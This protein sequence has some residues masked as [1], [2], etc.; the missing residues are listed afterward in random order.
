MKCHKIALLLSLVSA[1]IFSNSAFAGIL[2]DIDWLQS[3]KGDANLVIVDVQNKPGS[4]EKGHIPEAER[5]LRHV[6][7][8]DPTRYPANK[9]PG[10]RQFV[11][12]MSRLGID[13]NTTVVAYDD[14]P[15]VFASRILFILE[16]YGHDVDKLKLLNGGIKQWEAKGLNVSTKLSKTRVADRYITNGP[17]LTMLV[18]WSD[19]LHDVVHKQNTN[20]VL[21][22]ARP[23]KEFNGTKIRTIR[24]GHIPG[25]I[26]L[27]GVKAANNGDL[28]FKSEGDI[29]QK[30]TDAGISQDKTIYTY[31]HSS[32]RSAHA[33]M[34]MKHM[35]GYPNVKIYEGA[36]NE[37]GTMT[38]LPAADEIY[39]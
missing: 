14:K 38:A 10:T 2:V 33:Y 30:F 5:V 34:V 31:C 29:Q 23:A 26:N 11:Q 13:N 4:F 35:L 28:T 36:W 12:L 1:V 3:H 25:A 24:G 22:D 17:D 6:D 32:D 39:Q 18:T 15:S 8:E 37:W 27:E 16:L 21:H 20:I 7:L 9:Y 19:V